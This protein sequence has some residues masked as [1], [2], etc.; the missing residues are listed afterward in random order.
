MGTRSENRAFYST[1]EWLSLREIILK[2]D[3]HCCRNCGYGETLEV[4]HWL[5]LPVHRTEVDKL[6]Y[7][8]GDNPLIVHESGLVT[9]C[10]SCHEVLTGQRSRQVILKNPDLVRL[11]PNGTNRDNIFQIWALN[12]EKLPFRVRKET[13]SMK[14][15]QYYLVERIEI[16]KWPYGKAWGRYVRE[17]VAGELEKIANSG[18]YTWMLEAVTDHDPQGMN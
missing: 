13:W 10:K 11:G 3:G 16:G 18:T 8:L 14:V 5:P 2:R 17:G 7:G 12:G 6:G 15:S 1:E 4:H 9:L